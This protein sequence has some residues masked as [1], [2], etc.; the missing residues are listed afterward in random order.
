MDALAQQVAADLAALQARAA[1]GEDVVAE[2]RQAR[3]ASMNLSESERNMIADR[4]LASAA[5]VAQIALG[6][7]LRRV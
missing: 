4:L 2:L 3:A 1:K 7:A 6:V 5:F